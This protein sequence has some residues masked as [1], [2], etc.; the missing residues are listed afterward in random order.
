[1]PQTWQLK[2]RL[3]CLMIGFT[4]RIHFKISNIN[5]YRA[6]HCSVWLPRGTG[7]CFKQHHVFWAYHGLSSITL[8]TPFGRPTKPRFSDGL[9][10]NQCPYWGV[11]YRRVLH[12]EING[13]NGID[14]GI[15]L[16]SRDISRIYSGGIFWWN[17]SPTI[18]WLLLSMGS[19][20]QLRFTPCFFPRRICGW[21]R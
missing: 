6:I 11:R 5:F 9:G 7:E 12:G 13:N 20:N 10:S 1:M 17:S 18:S 2:I 19:L 16:Y 14:N 8:A 21:V 15:K 4:N 3:S